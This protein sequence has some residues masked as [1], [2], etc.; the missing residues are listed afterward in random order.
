MADNKVEIAVEE[1]RRTKEAAMG[2]QANS[3]KVLP[4]HLQFQHLL[5]LQVHLK[6]DLEEDG[7][8]AKV[9]GATDWPTC[10]RKRRSR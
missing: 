7:E 2:V 8:E 6:V 1:G 5:Q 3:N 10:H 4:L 9:E